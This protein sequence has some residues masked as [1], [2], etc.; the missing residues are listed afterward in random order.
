M[1]V[2]V[3]GHWTYAGDPAASDKDAV[4]Y[5]LGDTDEDDQKLSDEEIEY[6]LAQGGSVRATAARAARA[7]AASYALQP[8]T[9][10]V[11]DLEITF[12]NRAANFLV[13]ADRIQ[14]ES[15]LAAVPIAGGISVADKDRVAANADRVVPSFTR[16]MHDNPSV[17]WSGN[18]TTP[19]Y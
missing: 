12:G 17:N 2:I 1:P 16:G 19:G 4:R 10:K 15:S 11:G 7:L 3:G 6:E 5:L 18:S 14:A 13:I 9:K 8:A